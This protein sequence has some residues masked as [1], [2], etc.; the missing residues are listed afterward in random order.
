MSDPY[1]LHVSRSIPSAVHEAPEPP[2]ALIS[3]VELIVSK[4]PRLQRQITCGPSSPSSENTHCNTPLNPL[5]HLVSFSGTSATRWTMSSPLYIQTSPR[6]RGL[7]ASTRSSGLDKVRR[8][9]KACR[10]C[11]GQVEGRQRS[12]QPPSARPSDTTIRS[13]YSDRIS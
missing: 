10:W 3:K 11:A 2:E 1:C 4:I 7:G 12:A 9:L 5:C 13:E 8:A 6:A